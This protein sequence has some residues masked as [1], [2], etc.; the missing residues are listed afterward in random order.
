MPTPPVGLP[1]AA[2]APDQPGFPAQVASTVENVYPKTSVSYGP[3]P[4]GMAASTA[5]PSAARGM[6]GFLSANGDVNLFAGTATQIFR[7][8]STGGGYTWLDVSRVAAYTGPDPNTQWDF[9]FFNGQV[10]AAD[11]N[12]PLQAFNI[13]AGGIFADLAAAAPKAR[14]VEPIKNTF[15]MVGNTNDP[16]NGALPQRL[17]WCAAGDATNWPTP[18]S[19]TAAEFQAG[20]FDLLGTAGPITSLKSELT[21]ADGLVFQR[22]SLRRIIYV[23]PPQ[24]FDFLPAQ[25]AR[26]TSAPGAAIVVGGVCYFLGFDGFYTCDGAAVSP[27]GADKV[28]QTFLD[29][30]DPAYMTNVYAAADP[31]RK[32]IWWAYPGDGS[33]L[34][35]PNRMLGYSW[36]YD[37]WCLI[38]TGIVESI[39]RMFGI[40]FTLDELWTILGYTLDT[41]PAPLDS[42]L[43]QGGSQVLATFD[44]NHKLSLFT[45]PSMGALVETQEQEPVPGKRVIVTGVR[46]M[47]DGTN[48]T[49]PAVAIKHREIAGAT[50]AI[51]PYVDINALGKSPVRSSGRYVRASISIPAGG[52]W[53]NLS[54]AEVDVVQQGSR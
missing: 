33:S 45:G 44:S 8:S 48:V 6:A 18:G 27:M 30:L 54:G 17:W 36:Q 26:G 15:V 49:V 52:D 42:T 22:D 9:T 25:N 51:T 43:W 2:Y 47:V 3:M 40:G 28:N 34:G 19:I 38:Q 32:M 41:L 13:N 4:S 35:T 1:I 53:E 23:G 16:L 46:P 14:Y 31:V 50:P 29:D 12:D 20:A 11:Y 24:I 5:L 7:V 10:I 21:S 37:R 39:S